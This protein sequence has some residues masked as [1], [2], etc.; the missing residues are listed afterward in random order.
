M[1]A[2]GPNDHPLFDVIDYNLTVYGTVCDELIKQ[3]STFVSRD[4]MYEMYDWFDD[5][6]LNKL[7]EF[8]VEL[9]TKLDELKQR[10]KSNGWEI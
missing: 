2:G 6:R 9:R 4:D 3:I 7:Q 1:A 8:E 5:N 10:A